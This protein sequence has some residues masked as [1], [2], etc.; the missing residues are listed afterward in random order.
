M[1]E[2]DDK[3]CNVCFECECKCKKVKN[4][5]TNKTAYDKMRKQKKGRLIYV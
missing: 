3:N 5:F 1:Y 4:I 2:Q